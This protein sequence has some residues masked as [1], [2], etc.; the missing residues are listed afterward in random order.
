MNFLLINI[1]GSSTKNLCELNFL[2]EGLECYKY[3]Q[4]KAY[5]NRW[6]EK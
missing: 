5:D 2:W 6:T 1:Y 3:T 4:M